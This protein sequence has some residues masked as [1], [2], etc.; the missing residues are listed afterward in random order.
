MI[1]EYQPVL[2]I[3]LSISLSKVLDP[4]LP[5]WA[6]SPGDWVVVVVGGGVVVVVVVGVVV[7]L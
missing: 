6:S 2:G 1:S 4:L 3:L 5:L 7:V